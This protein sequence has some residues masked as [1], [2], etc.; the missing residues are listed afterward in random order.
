VP[1]GLAKRPRFIYNEKMYINSRR[2]LSALLVV[3]A[4]GG[5]QQLSPVPSALSPSEWFR[6]LIEEQCRTN[7][8]CCARPAETWASYEECVERRA[9]PADMLTEQ[10][11]D[12]RIEW[13][14][15]AAAD[16]IRG[17]RESALSCSEA[18]RAEAFVRGLVPEGGDCGGNLFVGLL[19]CLPGLTCFDD[20]AGFRC[21]TPAGL[22]EDCWAAPCSSGF[23]CLSSG[24]CE[25]PPRL[26]EP[27]ALPL[28]GTRPVCDG[29]FWC[30]RGICELRLAD[31]A[32]CN[33]TDSSCT[34]ACIDG[35]C[36]S[37]FSEVEACAYPPY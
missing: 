11:L 13:L 8:L 14:P 1:R 26:G 24:V 25:R 36:R 16:S 6:A 9:G 18:P 4:A 3:V 30:D 28:E 22:G 10:L 27:C 15:E 12:P 7:T 5:C 32:R 2:F 21:R 34:V 35:V 37:D 29:A 23:A 17:L 33:A 20:G 31:G 19:G